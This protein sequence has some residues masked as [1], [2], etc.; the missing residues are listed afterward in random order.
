MGEWEEAQGYVLAWPS[1]GT[2]SGAS[3]LLVKG[4]LDD[5]RDAVPVGYHDSFL[6]FY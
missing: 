2:L 4:Y 1:F 3:E 5:V 6:R